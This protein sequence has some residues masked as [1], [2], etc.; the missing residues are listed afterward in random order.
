MPNLWQTLKAHFC[1]HDAETR[2]L[3]LHFQGSENDHTNRSDLNNSLC[4]DHCQSLSSSYLW[5]SSEMVFLVPYFPQTMLL[6]DC[7]Q[8]RSLM[9][10]C[11][12]FEAPVWRIFPSFNYTWIIFGSFIPCFCHL[13]HSSISNAI[14]HLQYLAH[15]VLFFQLKKVQ[16]KVIWL[17]LLYSR[18]QRPW[19]WQ[20]LLSGDRA[21]A[22]GL[23]P[24]VYR[25]AIHYFS[26]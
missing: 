9:P 16:Y 4:P 26:I 7:H 21:D 15:L 2:A 12:V 14:L 24:K 22:L 6:C 11:T 10:Q 17:H 25:M 5:N 18:L 20:M 3:I 1:L 23:H 19:P 13:E 8:S